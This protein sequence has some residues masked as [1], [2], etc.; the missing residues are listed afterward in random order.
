LEQLEAKAD[1]VILPR[2]WSHT[3]LQTRIDRLDWRGTDDLCR[4]LIDATGGWPILL[5][6]LFARSSSQDDLRS[7]A[8]DISDELQDPNSPLAV[9]FRSQMAI[10]AFPEAHQ[11]LN[12]LVQFEEDS[13]PAEFVDP[14][15]FPSLAQTAATRDRAIEFLQRMRCIAIDDDLIRVEPIVL[16]LLATA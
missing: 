15:S 8:K 6:E 14:K 11:V 5:D 16:T 13:V 3:A 7:V 4:V 10:D 9:R 1:A 2:R 12:F